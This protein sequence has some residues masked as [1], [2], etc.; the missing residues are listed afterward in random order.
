MSSNNVKLGSIS[1]INRGSLP[2]RPNEKSKNK[3]DYYNIKWFDNQIFRYLEEGN[4]DVYVNY[5]S[6][7]E[8]KSIE[9]YKGKR[10]FARQ[11]MSRQFRMNLSII[12][13]DCAFKKNIYVIYDLDTN[14]FLLEYILSILNSKLFSFIQVN[15]NASLQRDDFPAFSLRDFKNFSVAKNS[16]DNQL[17]FS[18]KVVLILNYNDNL[19]EIA[20][21][22]LNL[23]ESKFNISKSPKKL[24]NWHELEFREFLKELE[25]SS[26]K[27]AKENETAYNKLT[28]SEEAKWMQYFNE[29]K[30]KV[31]ELKTEIDKTDR[32]IDQMVYELY[33]LTQ[34]EIEIVENATK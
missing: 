20:N 30:Q 27:S 6:L 12:D 19:Q 26:K 33:G 29:Q 4:S 7:R 28:L 18:K 21:L 15:F 10:I 8:N 32:E 11:L 31:E 1:K 16:I 5:E 14:K 22:F 23:L 17:I 34:E 13:Y 9:V 3:N 25:K 24:Q 2:P